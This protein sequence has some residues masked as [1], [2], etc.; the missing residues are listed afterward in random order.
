[1]QSDTTLTFCSLGENCL[2]QGILDRRDLPN[3]VS[4]FSWARTN[5]DYAIECLETSFDTLLRDEDLAHEERYKRQR[6][7]N[8]HFTAEP[9]LFERSVSAGFEFTHHDVILNPEHLE[10]YRRKIARMNALIAGNAGM[11]VFFYH[12]RKTSNP[13]KSRIVAKLQRFVDLCAERGPGRFHVL[14][15]SQILVPEPSD[16][17]L[18][19][20]RSGDVTH[21]RF[22]TLRSW[23][24]NDP[25]VLWA[26]VDDD[27]LDQMFSQFLDPLVITA[28]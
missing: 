10:S 8:R 5:I 13:D 9:G 25:H 26:K 3:I 4:P 23:A 11:T 24:G 15:M 12:H 16:R 14:M 20:T 17:G 21:Y 22:R 7:V 27:L 2:P 28:L 19:K 18:E 6:V 1:M